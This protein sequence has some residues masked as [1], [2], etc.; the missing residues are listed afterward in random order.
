MDASRFPLYF[1]FI[2]TNLAISANPHKQYD[3]SQNPRLSKHA[4]PL[5]VGPILTFFYLSKG[6][7]TKNKLSAATVAKH[8]PFFLSI[9]LNNLLKDTVDGAM[10][11]VFKHIFPASNSFMGLTTKILGNSG[12]QT[13][14]CLASSK[15]HFSF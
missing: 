8:K 13:V 4:V 7:T 5:H 6:P 10:V 2:H 11:F 14:D 3:V 1:R 15:H 12:S 9:F